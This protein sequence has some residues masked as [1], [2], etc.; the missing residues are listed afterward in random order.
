MATTIDDKATSKKRPIK[1]HVVA[2]TFLDHVEDGDEPMEC[3]V[4]GRLHKTTRQ[5]Y[6]VDS[7]TCADE[8]VHEDNKK[9]FVILKKVV[10]QIDI[11]SPRS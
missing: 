9:R 7:W 3:T 1:G 10:S 11:L 4:Y 8:K 6:I 2:I 5:S